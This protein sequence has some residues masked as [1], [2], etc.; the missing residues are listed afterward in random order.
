MSAFIVNGMNRLSGE[1]QISGGKNAVLP[2][3][4][5]TLL[6]RD[7]I[8]IRNCPEISDVSDMT[9]ILSALGVR[10]C[11]EGNTITAC[12]SDIDTTCMPEELSHKIRSSIFLLGSM[13]ARKGEAC[14]FP[15]GGCEIGRRPIDQHMHALSVMGVDAIWRD[16]KLICQTNG[17]KGG[18]IDLRFP[19]VGATENAMLAA[20]LANGVTVINGAAREPEI[21]CLAQMLRS[22][23]AKIQG[24]GTGCIVAEGVKNMHGTDFFCMPDR[25]EACTFLT[26]AAAAGGKI[27][28]TGTKP[29]SY[30]RVTELLEK[31]G[32]SVKIYGDAVEIEMDKRADAFDLSTAP[33]PGFP[34]DMQAQ[35]CALACTAKGT[36]HITETVFENRL[37]HASE[38]EKTGAEVIKEDNSIFITGKEHLYAAELSATDLRSGAALVILALACEGQSRVT[39]TG[40]IDRGYECFESKLRSIGA[41][42]R[43]V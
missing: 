24:D 33:Y 28:V 27:A 40:Y 39:G 42:I 11:K 7:E 34:T 6:T 2:L 15:P 25:I 16:E 38:L 19:S 22:M 10:I 17:I 35:M 43:R 32:A 12:A 23:G 31:I 29:E 4:A 18:I 5:A 37:R 20:V 26:A 8:V 14:F 41:D 21:C 36:S 30:V 9:D 13:L 3:L 1:V